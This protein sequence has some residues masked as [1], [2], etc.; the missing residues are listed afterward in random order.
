M[1]IGTHRKALRSG[2]SHDSAPRSGSVYK[3]IHRDPHPLGVHL[4][5][6]PDPPTLV[7]DPH[8]RLLA[9]VVPLP[10]HRAPQSTRGRDL[11]GYAHVLSWKLNR[12]LF[13][14]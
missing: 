9:I 14:N 7:F 5:T 2:T 6:A 1:T 3:I 13:G 10:S 12:P 11:F 8:R 4:Y